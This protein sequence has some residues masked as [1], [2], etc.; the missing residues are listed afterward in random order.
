MNARFDDIAALPHGEGKALALS[1]WKREQIWKEIAEQRLVKCRD[2]LEALG[3]IVEIV[4][5][6][7]D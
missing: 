6:A 4:E 1:L 3:K 7:T 5:E 2:L